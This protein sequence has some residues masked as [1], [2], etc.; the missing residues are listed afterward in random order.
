[1]AAMRCSAVWSRAWQVVDK[2]RQGRQA[3]FKG[4]RVEGGS[5][6]E[7]ASPERSREASGRHPL[8]GRD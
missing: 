4:H 6:L 8:A 2:I 1:M 7:G 5:W 3:G